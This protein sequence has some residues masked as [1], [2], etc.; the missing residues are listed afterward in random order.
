MKMK[1]QSL[2]NAHTYLCCHNL[3][4]FFIIFLFL[5]SMKHQPAIWKQ[6]RREIRMISLCV[7]ICARGERRLYDNNN[8]KKASKNWNKKNEIKETEEKKIFVCTWTHIMIL[9]GDNKN[10]CINSKII[11]L[12]MDQERQ[13]FFYIFLSFLCIW[14]FNAHARL[15]FNKYWGD[16]FFPFHTILKR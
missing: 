9:D 14:I 11:T 15:C 5:A 8:K 16:F 2:T 12:K 13:Q 6:W 3:Y 10:K 7:T 4:I 1:S